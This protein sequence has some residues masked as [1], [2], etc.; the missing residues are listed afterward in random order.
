MAHY[1]INILMIISLLNTVSCALDPTSLAL[2][3][4]ALQAGTVGK[5][6]ATTAAS[7]GMIFTTVT[8]GVA[9][10]VIAGVIIYKSQED[11]DWYDPI[12]LYYRYSD[13]YTD[14]ID[15]I[16]IACDRK[17]ST[18]SSYK[19]V[20]N[21]KIPDIGV[22]YYYQNRDTKWTTYIGMRKFEVKNGN[23]VSYHYRV[24]HMP[25]EDI[26]N[27]YNSFDRVVLSGKNGKDEYIITVYS[28]DTSNYIP[29]LIIL[30]KI[31]EKPKAHQQIVLDHIMNHFN[32]WFNHGNTKA[33]ITGPAGVGKS[34]CALLLKNYYEQQYPN[35]NV[36]VI[37]DF[38]PSAIGVNI[39]E[40]VLKH[41][42]KSNPVI[43]VINEID[44]Y[45]EATVNPKSSY[46]DSR[47][48]HTRNKGTF[49]DMLD[50]IAS[51]P[52]VITLFTTNK[53]PKE[54]YSNP[55]YES[56]LRSGRV[57]FF[58]EMTSDSAIK[59]ENNKDNIMN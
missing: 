44:I 29:K 33:A 20:S 40:V 21:K 54:L 59:V 1:I 27:V 25:T 13:E 58:I 17:C 23:S 36:K 32:N 24:Y 49:N 9:G 45:Y 16:L 28:I 43:L 18:I 52:Y 4:E 53:T 14:R 39:A 15:D 2:L 47:I 56:F 30:S 42:S 8:T 10:S 31:C 46:G 37:I 26:T 34:Y 57:D 12:S 51:T 48:Q 50:T 41:A 6:A 3:K 7:T 55:N 22:H 19:I 35:S 11:P 5:T 38:D